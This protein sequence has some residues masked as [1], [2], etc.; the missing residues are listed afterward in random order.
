MEEAQ[1]RLGHDSCG[2]GCPTQR[3][4]SRPGKE[5]SESMQTI[6]RDDPSERKSR[7]EERL[8]ELGVPINTHLP[9][10]EDMDEATRRTKEEI[11]KST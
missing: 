7:S 4:N 5:R 3:P 8:G 10:I 2:L 6:V 11:A 9:V 1:L